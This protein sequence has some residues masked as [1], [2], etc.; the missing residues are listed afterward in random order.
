MVK[1]RVVSQ[2]REEIDFVS[3]GE[4]ST[5]VKAARLVAPRPITEMH[6][7]I[8]ILLYI[9]IWSDITCSTTVKLYRI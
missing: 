1:G 5:T 3:T 6:A 9:Y 2:A 7:Q 4:V 8:Y